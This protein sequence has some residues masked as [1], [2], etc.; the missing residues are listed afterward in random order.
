MLARLVGL[1]SA[2]C[3]PTG[4]CAA[5]CT[6]DAP[7]SSPLSPF[8]PGGV[9]LNTSGSSVRQPLLRFLRGPDSSCP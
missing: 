5:G 9:L 4:A 2:I 1:V 3:R 8:P 7:L 6:F